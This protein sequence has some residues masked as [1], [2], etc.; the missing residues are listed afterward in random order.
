M[1]SLNNGELRSSGVRSTFEERLNDFTPNVIV[2]RDGEE[3]EIPMSEF[4]DEQAR[5]RSEENQS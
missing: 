1:T 2:E 5:L 3:V 4:L